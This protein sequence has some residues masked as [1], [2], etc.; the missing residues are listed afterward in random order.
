MSLYFGGIVCFV[1]GVCL[2]MCVCI[3]S[4]LNMRATALTNFEV[5]NTLL[6]TAG[7][8]V[9]SRSLELLHIASPNLYSHGDTSRCRS[10]F[11][12][13]KEEGVV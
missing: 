2:Y 10:A 7:T 4:T 9:C 8:T 3:V 6:L 1:W 11:S 5:Y 13:T 12:A